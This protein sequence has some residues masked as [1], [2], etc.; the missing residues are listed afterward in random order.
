M[1]STAYFLQAGQLALIFYMKTKK[2]P[3]GGGMIVVLKLEIDV[4]AGVANGG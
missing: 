3:A 2:Y 1:G 4:D